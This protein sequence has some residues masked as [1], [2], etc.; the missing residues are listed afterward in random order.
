MSRESYIIKQMTHKVAPITTKNSQVKDF[1]LPNV[2][3]VAPLARIDGG[4]L[5]G[6][7]AG[8]VKNDANGKITGGNNGG[9]ENHSDTTYNFNN[10][11]LYDFSTNV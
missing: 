6:F 11:T 1:V 2:S 10:K 5:Q 9:T 3:N 7:S 8:F 4:P